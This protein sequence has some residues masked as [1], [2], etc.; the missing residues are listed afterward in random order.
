[1]P[2]KPQYIDIEFKQPFA[3]RRLIIPV[4]VGMFQGFWA[5]VQVSS[6][7]KTWRT[8]AKFNHDSGGSVTFD[9]V[10]SKFYRILFTEGKSLAD[11]IPPVDHFSVADV[12]L[13]LSYRIN[14]F[15]VKSGMNE[16]AAFDPD[17][18]EVDAEVAI[19]PNKI[20]DL[21]SRMDKDGKLAWD[22]PPGRWTVLR[23][24]HTTTG[25]VNHPAPEDGCGL[26]CDKLS[27]AAIQQ[28]FANLVEKLIHDSGPESTKVMTY[29]HID[30]WEVGCQNWTEGMRDEFK[31][32]RG[33]DLLPFLPAMTGRPVLSAEA[34]ERFFFDL[35]RTIS[36]MVN[37]YYATGL[38]DL[39][40]PY[41]MKLSIEAYGNGPLDCLSYAGR[42]DMPIAEFWTGMDLHNSL[43]PMASSGHIYGKRII[44]AEAFT[45][46]ENASRQRNHPGSIKALG[47]EAFCN[48]INRFVF[49]RFSM[50][51]WV[52][53]ARAPGMTMGPWGLEYERTATWWEQTPAWHQYLARCQYLLQQGTFQADLLYL[54]SEEGFVP[55]KTRK[56]M[57]PKIPAGYDYDMCAPEIVMTRASVKKGRIEIQGGMRYRVLVLP[58]AKRMTP[59]LLAKIKELVEAGATVV[60]TPPSKSPSYLDFPRCDEKVAALTI[61]L[62]GDGRGKAVTE[63]ACGKGKVVWGKPLDLILTEGGVEQD[64]SF[65]TADPSPALRAIHRC[66]DGTEIYFVAKRQ[67]A[68][69]RGDLFL[70]RQGTS[71]RVCGIPI[72]AKL[73]RVAVY[74]TN[75]NRV[76]L[77]I[78]FDPSGSVFVVFRQSRG[79]SGSRDRRDSRWKSNHFGRW[80]V[81]PKIVFVLASA[82]AAAITLATA[83]G[84]TLVAD[85]PQPPAALTVAG[86]WDVSFPPNLGAPPKVTF[87]KLISLSE[88]PAPGVKYFSGTATYRKTFDMPAEMLGKGHS[89]FA[90]PGRRAGER[91]S[92]TQRQGSGNPLE[93][94]VPSG[95]Q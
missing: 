1:M 36:E 89:L 13:N 64:F 33:Y 84:H 18:K 56:A 11:H 65:K 76:S 6:E 15:S 45:A 22:V 38:R 30:S 43:R 19:A 28:Q 4:Q 63:H 26:E 78:Q 10:A 24:G 54:E 95:D 23:L 69:G 60:G 86:P 49:H 35:R 37:D 75:G 80:N 58:E 7:G 85:V 20:V 44:A 88:H 70:P 31:R 17:I 74:E 46:M 8:I 68:A 32:R 55:A 42:C 29:T 62:W 61:G 3:A 81:L 39:A 87:E 52:K 9:K 83:S 5:E 67:S 73:N 57:N 79:G 16:S 82:A 47:D 91:A 50:Q 21:T 48:G 77:P 66:V 25:K 90:R 40:A 41:G 71:A 2:G 59:E 53:P 93:A 27:K 14:N 94:A 51:P 72:P 92:E 12:D 34:S